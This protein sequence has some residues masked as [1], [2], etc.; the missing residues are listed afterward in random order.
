MVDPCIGYSQV[1]VNDAVLKMEDSDGIDRY[2]VVNGA[3][4]A[5]LYRARTRYKGW[6]AGRLPE[7]GRSAGR[8]CHNGF[9]DWNSEYEIAALDIEYLVHYCSS[10]T[11][12]TANNALIRAKATHSDGWQK[13]S[14]TVFT[15]HTG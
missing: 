10:S 12:A 7:H 2:R 3:G 15:R 6:P 11:M 13:R 4:H 8:G 9:Q 1:V 5:L 14:S